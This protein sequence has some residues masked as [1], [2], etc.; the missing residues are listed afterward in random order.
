MLVS[1]QE[2]RVWGPASKRWVVFCVR[3]AQAVDQGL[4]FDSLSQAEF[5]EFAEQ[6]RDLKVR[7]VPAPH[8]ASGR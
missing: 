5:A 1:I 3:L 8:I 7:P 6:M 2:Q 4:G